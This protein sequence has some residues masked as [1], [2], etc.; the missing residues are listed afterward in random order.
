MPKDTQKDETLRKTFEEAGRPPSAR[1][2]EES[3]FRRSR[4]TGDALSLE[5]LVEETRL[6]LNDDFCRSLNKRRN[7]MNFHF[8]ALTLNRVG[9]K[10]ISYGF[11]K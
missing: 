3:G 8:L 10:R 9:I 5:K 2:T 1:P 6:T 7:N 11:G 4:D